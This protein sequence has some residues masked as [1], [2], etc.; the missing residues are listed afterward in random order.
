MSDEQ[1]AT[2]P[3]A[4]LAAVADAIAESAKPIKCPHCG[5][6]LY[7][8][9]KSKLMDSSRMSFTMHPHEGEL[10]SAKTI[11]GAIA[12]IDELLVAVGDELGVKTLVGVEG[13]TYTNGSVKVDLLLA[14]HQNGVEKRGPPPAPASPTSRPGGGE[15]GK[16]EGEG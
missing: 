15:A 4:G 11:G 8:G 13:I 5:G 6:E 1:I 12:A 16:Q 14:R 10:L 3:T 2:D 7:F 9:I